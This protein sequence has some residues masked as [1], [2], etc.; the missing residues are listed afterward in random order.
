MPH[1]LAVRIKIAGHFV[2][3]HKCF[4]GLSARN[5]LVEVACYLGVYLPY[6]AVKI[7]KPFLEYSDANC[8]KGNYRNNEKRKTCVHGEHND[9]NA[10]DV[11]KVPNAVHKRPRAKL[12]YAGG[13]AHY[14]R[15]D[16]ADAVLV[17]VGKRECLQVVKAR[18]AQIAAYAVLNACGKVGGNKVYRHLYDKKADVQQNKRHKRIKRSKLDKVV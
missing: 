8:S 9:D 7:G 2:L 13:V 14:S 17:K 1:F 4:Y 5:T 15:V 10:N 11:G 18:A 6:L 16:V 12:A 3:D